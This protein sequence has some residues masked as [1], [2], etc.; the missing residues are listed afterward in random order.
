M[1]PLIQAN[2]LSPIPDDQLALAGVTANQVDDGEHVTYWINDVYQVLRRQYALGG[3][4]H[5]NIRRRDGKPIFRDWRHFQE[6]KNQLIGPECEAVELYPAES[7]LA[8]S[9]NKYHL[10]GSLDPTY[11]FPFG[12]TGRRVEGPI[13]GVTAPG[14]RQRP[15]QK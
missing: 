11:R 5:L 7:R 4:V 8:D 2:T 13:P 14:M 6:I 10:W 1:K 15:F 12:F 3:M 9:S